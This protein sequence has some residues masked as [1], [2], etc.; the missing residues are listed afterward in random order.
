[1]KTEK[2]VRTWWISFGEYFDHVAW[3]LPAIKNSTQVIAYEDHLAIVAE[4]E[5]RI[6]KLRE[7]LKFY[8]DYTEFRELPRR[9][10]CARQ[11]LAEDEGK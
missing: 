11:A 9:G 8:C 6:Q 3:E 10:E 1:M 5:A 7:A 2:Q 4:L